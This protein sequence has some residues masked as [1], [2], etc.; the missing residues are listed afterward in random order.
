MKQKK[1]NVSDASEC[2]RTPVTA[3]DIITAIRLQGGTIRLAG[4]QVQVRIPGGISPDLA[5][6]MQAHKPAIV[7]HLSGLDRLREER[8]TLMERLDRSMAMVW[9]MEQAGQTGTPDYEQKYA[10]FDR[11]RAR[12]EY[13]EDRIMEIAEVAA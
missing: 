4:E 3:A 12:L 8:A 2:V 10:L 6:V 13:V 5:A 11:L 1:K 9:E 7:A